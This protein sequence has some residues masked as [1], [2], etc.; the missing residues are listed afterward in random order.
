[1]ATN[2]PD[3]TYV[4]F[5]KLL[6]SAREQAGVSREDCGL[7]V[8]G[9]SSVAILRYESGQRKLP[10]HMIPV[11]AEM[12]GKDISYFFQ[13]GDTTV[14]E[15]IT[16]SLP[17]ITRAGKKF[18]VFMAYCRGD[19]SQ[20]ESIYDSLKV[21]GI[22]P[23]IDFD[24]IPPGGRLQDA[25]QDV[26]TKVRS[27][28]VF[29]APEGSGIW[30]IVEQRTLMAQCVDASIPVIPVLLPGAEEVP[31]Q[32]AF[33]EELQGVRFKDVI[34]DEDAYDALVWGIT[35]NRPQRTSG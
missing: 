9:K 28:A 14:V 12:L 2:E 1:M 6:R 4:S 15:G 17:R 11:L 35:G 24:Q 31:R 22:H 13:D 30:E 21:K 10:L 18:D 32:L 19:R 20:V 26:I 7:A 29:I 27:M 16:P 3:P 23:W 8:G 25:L 34:Q 5:G 33:L